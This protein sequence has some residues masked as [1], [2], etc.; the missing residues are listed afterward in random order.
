MIARIIGFALLLVASAALAEDKNITISSNGVAVATLSVPEAAKVT[1]SAEKTAVDTKDLTLYLWVVPKAKTVG[2]VIPK[3]AEVIKGEVKD[4]VVQRTNTITVAGA[5]AKHL[6]G[7]GKE[8]DDGDPASADVVVFTVG[9]TVLVACVH[10]EGETAPR[11]R[12]AMLAILK[13]AKAP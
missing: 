6:I 8:A 10:G 9:K 5:E 11:Q 2:K 7:S 4:F 3:V 13:T 1:S 12:P